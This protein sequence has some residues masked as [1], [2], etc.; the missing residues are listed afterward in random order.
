MCRDRGQVKAVNAFESTTLCPNDFDG[1]CGSGCEQCVYGIRT[2]DRSLGC[3]CAVESKTDVLVWGEAESK[4]D[5]G[6]IAA[7]GELC[8]DCRMSWHYKD[9]DM[10]LGTT[11]AYRCRDW[12]ESE[13]VA[14]RVR[15][16]SDDL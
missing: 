7:C 14:P 13:V 11:A 1:N 16:V 8:V 3:Y 6:D 10:A 12:K 5:G 9:A 4:V 2:E 15:A